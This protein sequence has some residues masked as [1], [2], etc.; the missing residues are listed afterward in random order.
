ML[1]MA[2]DNSLG[3]DGQDHSDLE[4]I[5]DIG[6]GEHVNLVVLQDGY[7]QD[8]SRLF[9]FDGSK[10]IEMPAPWLTDEL[11]MAT[12]NTLFNFI[13][14][15]IQH[16]PADRF[17]LDI[18][19]HGEG[20]KS[21]SNDGSDKLTGLE[22]GS[23]IA[24]AMAGQ[25]RRLDVIGFDSCNMAM[26]EVYSQ[27]IGYAD[28]ALASEKEEDIDGWN[29]ATII[30]TLN[31]H[32]DILPKDLAASI[33]SGFCSWSDTNS[34]H[35]AALSVVDLDILNSLNNEIMELV[36]LLVK[37]VGFY[38]QDII[39][40]REQ[41]QSYRKTPYPYDMKHFLKNLQKIELPPS[42]S[43]QVQNII[44]LFPQ[45]VYHISRSN[46]TSDYSEN[47]S[48]AHGISVWFPNQYNRD[49][50]YE[51]LA[52]VSQT[53][54][55]DF[56]M[57][58]SSTESRSRPL[59]VKWSRLRNARDDGKHLNITVQHE[60]GMTTFLSV[61]DSTGTVESV[62]LTN[63]SYYNFFPLRDTYYDICVELRDMYGNLYNYT[64][65]KDIWVD[66]E[67]PYPRILDVNMYSDSEGFVTDGRVLEGD[68][69]LFQTI[70]NA[71][72]LSDSSD[73]TLVTEF[74]MDGKLLETKENIAALN[75]LDLHWYANDIGK[76]TLTIKTALNQVTDTY[77]YQFTVRSK[78]PEEDCHI[79]VDGGDAGSMSITNLRTDDVIQVEFGPRYQ[80]VDVS[81][82]W[83]EEGDLL[84]LSIMDKDGA[85]LLTKNIKAEGG[86]SYTIASQHSE[87]EEGP[88]GVNLL[89]LF[90]GIILLAA[91]ALFIH[92]EV[93]GKRNRLQ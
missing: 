52:F 88:E 53:G 89:L 60:P 19:D 46:G 41:T 70:V 79:L 13:N 82:G 43:S 48:E 31:M 38:H 87:A 62:Q 65:V 63:G 56:L 28:F 49:S 5:K 42:A 78:I 1:Y 32:P 84:E 36:D 17:F 73:L 35:S 34:E 37:D 30:N 57:E 71:L 22:L 77:H 16:F 86:T 33:A 66:E 85:P 81:R 45:V 11:N 26:A 61:Q 54:W 21:A 29:Y 83:F 51:G 14:F 91:G 75:F 2:A 24:K 23:G 69:L 74:Y 47:V 7:G 6:V 59:D 18:W 55:G 25:D 12:S 20:W 68:L 64:I 58:L 15:S 50:G 72:G 90:P 40:A 3:K 8:N 80:T 93:F 4:E 67:Y 76:R 44:D 27:L 9:R 92:I 10:I 39:D